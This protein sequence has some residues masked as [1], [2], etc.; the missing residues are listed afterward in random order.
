MPSPRCSTPASRP[1]SG[2]D[3][4]SEPAV[5]PGRLAWVVGGRAGLQCQS[6]L[7]TGRRPSLPRLLL[8]GVI[9]GGPAILGG[10]FLNPVSVAGL[11]AGILALYATSLLVTG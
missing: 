9:A 4:P 5:D 1:F 7:S 10:R 8:L 6:P 2:P 3:A 11:W